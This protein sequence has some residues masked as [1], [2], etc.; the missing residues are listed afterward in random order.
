V[1]SLDALGNVLP[2]IPDEA[3]KIERETARI[4]G[5]LVNGRVEPA[6]LKISAHTYRVAVENG[7][8][9]S[10]SVALSRK[11]A[12]ADLVEAWREFRAA[13]EV[14]SLPSAP[15][16]PLAYVDEPHAP[17]PRRHAEREGGMVTW[18]GGLSRCAVLDWK[19]T[20][21]GNNTVRGAAGGSLLNA[22][23]LVRARADSAGLRLRDAS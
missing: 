12:A 4:L 16:R 15:E 8:T 11:A 10:V 23:L 3:D 1:A 5:R 17:Q 19:F 22:E 18:I 14:A 21:V 9:E 6:P 20:V 7:H 13:P 2:D